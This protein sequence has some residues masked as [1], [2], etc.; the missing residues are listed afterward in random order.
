MVRDR[1]GHGRGR[2]FAAEEVIGVLARPFGVDIEVA[3][4][5]AGNLLAIPS[6]PLDRERQNALRWYRRATVSAEISGV[7]THYIDFLN[8]NRYT[9]CGT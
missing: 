8:W 2:V 9:M 1:S 4:E 7:A 3:L 5:A 6:S